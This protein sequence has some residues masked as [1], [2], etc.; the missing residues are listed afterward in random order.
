MREGYHPGYPSRVLRGVAVLLLALVPAPST[1]TGAAVARLAEEM[2]SE[3]VRVARGRAVE[4]APAAEGVVPGPSAEWRELLLARLEGRVRLAAEGP[5]VRV[6]WA[7]TDAPARLL[8]SARLVEAPGGKLLDIVSVSAPSDA[9]TVPLSPQ[10][11]A[12]PRTAV[13]VI[14]TSRSAPIQGV[15]L[16]LAW[17][18]DERVLTVFRD[19]AA[20]YRLDASA[21]VLESH[22]ALP[23]PLSAVRS[24]GAMAV[25]EAGAAWVL[26][27]ATA[28]AALLAAED[29]RLVVRSRAD[30]LPWPGSATGL[31]FRGG[32]NLVEVDAAGLGAGPFLALEPSGIAGVDG[33]GEL[34]LATGEGGARAGLRAGS[35]VAALWKGMLAVSSSAPPADVDAVSLVAVSDQGAEVAET[36]PVEGTLR[37]LAS[38]ASGEGVRLLAAVEEKGPQSRLLLM[39][40]RRRGP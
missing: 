36:I 37:A 23:R 22:R 27:S 28:S 21:L 40:L 20:L 2:A 29:G 11:S 9:G 7:A 14:A 15:V 19:E 35:A 4:V 5:R 39:D 1:E 34:R 6:D 3:V 30:A 31:R 24:P 12:S 8:A 25:A 13:D 26:T 10:R 18:S 16:A 17:I 38:R 32:T 33:E